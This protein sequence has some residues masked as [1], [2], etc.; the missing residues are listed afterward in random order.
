VPSGRVDVVDT[1]EVLGDSKGRATPR[2]GSSGSWE[3]G[4]GFGE[5][6]LRSVSRERRHMRGADELSVEVWMGLS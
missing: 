5:G 2:Q 1:G 3:D 4:I 6:M